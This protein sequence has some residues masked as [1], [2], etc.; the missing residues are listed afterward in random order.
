M[1]TATDELVGEAGQVGLGS[2]ALTIARSGTPLLSKSATVMP[3]GLQTERVA[4]ALKEPFAWPRLSLTVLL[5]ALEM[6][7]SVRPSPLKSPATARGDGSIGVNDGELSC[8]FK[9]EL[10]KAA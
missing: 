2:P 4:D 1:K 3:V 8:R 5:A 7:M 10:P 9:E 6:A